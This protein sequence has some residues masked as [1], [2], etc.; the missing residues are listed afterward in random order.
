MRKFLGFTITIVLILAWIY[1]IYRYQTIRIFT[2]T[3]PPILGVIFFKNKRVRNIFITVFVIVWMVIFH[4]ESTRYFYWRTDLQEKL[5]KTKFLFPPLGWIMYYNVG[6]S[7]GYVEVYGV[8]DGIPQII[9]PHDIFRVRTIGY[10]NIHRGILG[11]VSYSSQAPQFCRYLQRRFPYFD[12]FAV[13]VNQHRN[14]T[15]EPY[16]RVQQVRYQCP[17]ASQ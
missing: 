10:D 1:V 17:G 15:A 2:S 9:D 11:T 7:A 12:S 4:Y 3:I 16:R 14:L 8:K 5:P 13:T 6:N